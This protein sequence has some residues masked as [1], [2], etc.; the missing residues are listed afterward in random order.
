[1]VKTK[2]KI[3][4]DFLNTLAKLKKSVKICMSPDYE[5]YCD[6]ANN[7]EWPKI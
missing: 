5:K 4:F 2:V 7:K 1:M 6:N 3:G